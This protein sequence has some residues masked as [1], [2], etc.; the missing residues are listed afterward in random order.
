MM[1]TS[2]VFE[3]NHYK[4]N[5][6]SEYKWAEFTVNSVRIRCVLLMII[7]DDIGDS[8]INTQIEARVSP[9]S[10][11]TVYLIGFRYRRRS[12]SRNFASFRLDERVYS[13]DMYEQ[14]DDDMKLVIENERQ[15]E[16]F[17]DNYN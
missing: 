17:G 15:N 11:D 7:I 6:N 10:A 4:W 13:D 3:Y 12:I 8:L 5:T 1:P 9:I 14:M 2:V 16:M